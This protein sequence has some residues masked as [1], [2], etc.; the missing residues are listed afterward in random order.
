MVQ[1]AER[2]AVVLTKHVFQVLL[3]RFFVNNET[4]SPHLSPEGTMSKH[5]SSFQDLEI[6]ILIPVVKTTG[7]T[8]LPLRG[9]FHVNPR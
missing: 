9:N 4:T 8:T 7:Y 1:R 6:L 3:F 5:T 2:F